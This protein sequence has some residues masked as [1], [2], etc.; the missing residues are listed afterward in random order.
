VTTKAKIKISKEDI[1]GVAKAFE[2]PPPDPNRP[3]SSK[4]T[5]IPG[6][7]HNALAAL[8]IAT[9]KAER[10]PL[11]LGVLTPLAELDKAK[12]DLMKTK[13]PTITIRLE[14]RSESGFPRIVTAHNSGSVT[15]QFV[16]P[17]TR[18]EILEAMQD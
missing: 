13:G 10:E 3:E 8:L 16:K 9:D 2:A 14:D 12:W 7:L 11:G 18:A 15:W 1:N 6:S 4:T 17:L 5:Q